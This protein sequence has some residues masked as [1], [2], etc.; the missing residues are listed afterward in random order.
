MSDLVDLICSL[1]PMGVGGIQGVG[2]AHVRAANSSHES[3]VHRV[4]I[5]PDDHILAIL[6]LQCC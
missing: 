6:A 1:A 5:A 3:A 4:P 2:R